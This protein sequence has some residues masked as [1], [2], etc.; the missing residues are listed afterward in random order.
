VIA[1]SERGKLTRNE[2][3]EYQALAQEVQRLD[4]VRAVAL[5]ELARRREKSVRAVKAEIGGEGR[6]DGACGDPPGGAATGRDRARDC[7]EYCRH[8]ASYSCAPF[9]CEQVLPLALGAGSTV[10]ELAWACPAC[11]GHRGL[12]GVKGHSWGHAYFLGH[13]RCP[14]C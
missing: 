1:R 4:A 14:A 9:V 2:L 13:S 8:P 11:N 12:R 7:C 5:A 6:S 10:A 3:A